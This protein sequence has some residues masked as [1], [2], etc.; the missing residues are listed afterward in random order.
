MAEMQNQIRQMQQE[1]TEWEEEKKKLHGIRLCELLKI[2][3]AEELT[4]S[5]DKLES[6]YA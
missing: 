1:R 3:S 4:K 5:C 2:D 6:S